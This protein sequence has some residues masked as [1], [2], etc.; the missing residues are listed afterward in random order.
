MLK[1]G[2]RSNGR[3]DGAGAKRRGRR[4]S[5]P[6]AYTLTPPRMCAAPGFP[7]RTSARVCIRDKAQEHRPG[8]AL[9]SS[10]AP[11]LLSTRRSLR[12]RQAPYVPGVGASVLFFYMQSPTKHHRPEREFP[13]SRSFPRGGGGIRERAAASISCACCWPRASSA[14]KAGWP[15][16]WGFLWVIGMGGRFLLA[17]GAAG[18]VFGSSSPTRRTA[19]PAAR[20][21]GRKT[22]QVYSDVPTPWPTRHTP[23]SFFKCPFLY[24]STN[25]TVHPTLRGAAQAT[26]RATSL[27]SYNYY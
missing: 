9:C 12:G 21:D 5:A 27:Q 24:V 7:R 19:V 17:R 11:M 3:V 2:V 14:P 16:P 23:T 8:S 6:S 26:R 25:A 18:V 4:A 10:D 20:N 15:W 13:G 1:E 22:M